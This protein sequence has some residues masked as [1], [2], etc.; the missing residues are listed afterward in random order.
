MQNLN[1]GL[2]DLKNKV[3]SV[4]AEIIDPVL[5]Q[6]RIDKK[7]RLILKTTAD[8]TKATKELE[9]SEQKFHKISDFLET[10]NVETYKEKKALIEQKKQRLADLIKEMGLLSDE[11]LRGVRKQDLL[12]EVPCGSQYPSCKFIKDAHE[13]TTLV[14]VTESK[15]S[16]NA[17]GQ[18]C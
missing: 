6:Q 10:F 3:E 7:E 16:T 18:I 12:L 5:T 15:M 4:P 2:S 17:V 1:I 8:K 13:A 14:Q 11:K 9:Q